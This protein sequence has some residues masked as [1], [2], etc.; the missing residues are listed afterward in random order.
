VAL[1]RRFPRK[2]VAVGA[3]VATVAVAGIATAYFSASGSGS[4]TAAVGSAGS[5]ALTSSV[6]GNLY[7]GATGVPVSITATNNGSGSEH[8]ATVHL[9][10]VTVDSGH[11]TCDVSAFTMPDVT[12]NQTL[13][14]GANTQA[15]GTLSMA[16]TAS[17]QDACQGATLTLNLTS[18]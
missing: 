11:S 18:N 17:N 10:S 7:P 1:S 5:V 4:G 13:A 12:V 14:V 6:T 3:V 8:V 16:N 2:Y 15:S 9:A